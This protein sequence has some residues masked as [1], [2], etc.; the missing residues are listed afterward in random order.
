MIKEDQGPV[1]DW[2]DISWDMKPKAILDP[3]LAKTHT[4]TSIGGTIGKI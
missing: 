2:R 1:L 3:G 4:H